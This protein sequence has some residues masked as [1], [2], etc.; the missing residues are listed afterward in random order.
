MCGRRRPLV[1]MLWSGRSRGLTYRL[2]LNVVAAG[3]LTYRLTLAAGERQR[4]PP[5]YAVVAGEIRCPLEIVVVDCCSRSGDSTS[6]LEIV[7][8]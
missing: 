1:I 7:V 6:P 3:G 4:A 8:T 5:M 2:I